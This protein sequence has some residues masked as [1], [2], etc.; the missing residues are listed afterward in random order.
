MITIY[1][2]S[3]KGRKYL[4]P[5]EQSDSE[6]LPIISSAFFLDTQKPNAVY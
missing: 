1:R 5:F 2:K 4:G 6:E 3:D